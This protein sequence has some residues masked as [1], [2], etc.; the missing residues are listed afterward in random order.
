MPEGGTESNT[1]CKECVS[2]AS[3]LSVDGTEVGDKALQ[4]GVPNGKTKGLTRRP[5]LRA[6]LACGYG[7]VGSLPPKDT[8]I[9]RLAADFV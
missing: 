8:L 9:L 3:P 7:G 4:V 5:V 1:M 2:T 6:M